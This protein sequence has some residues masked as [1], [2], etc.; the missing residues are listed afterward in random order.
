MY[1]KPVVV[2]SQDVLDI[3]CPLNCSCPKSVYLFGYALSENRCPCLC[4]VP[5]SVLSK[6]IVNSLKYCKVAVNWSTKRCFYEKLGIA[7]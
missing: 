2:I 5:K 1:Q 7:I 3:C 6:G 4:S